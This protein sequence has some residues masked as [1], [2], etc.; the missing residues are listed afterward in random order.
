MVDKAVILARGLGT[1]MQ[2]ERDGVELDERSDRIARQGLKTLIPVGGRPFLD[3]IVDSLLEAGLHQVCLVIAP[4]CRPLQDYA[5]RVSRASDAEMSWTVQKEALGTADAVL[6]AE[7]FAGSDPFVLCNSDNLY[8]REA[9]RTLSA[10]EK[11]CCVAAFDSDSLVT[12]GNI[13]RERVRDMAVVVADED[14]N[15]LEIVEKPPEP[16]KYARDSQVWVN[17]NL[18]RFP[19]EIFDACRNIEPD[20][21]RGELELTSAV[22]LLRDRGAVPFRVVFSGDGVLDMT[23]R[24]D[25]DSGRRALEDRKPGF[26]PSSR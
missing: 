7:S 14:G 12:Q 8:P 6:A 2:K 11:G 19:P 15:L 3:Y 25:V 4:D 22:Q 5:D 20:P 9:L 24:K 10:A 17:M 18:Y 21:E 16:E 13:A 26:P 23:S 1:R